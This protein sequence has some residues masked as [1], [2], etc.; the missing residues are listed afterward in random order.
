VTLTAAATETAFAL[1]LGPR[2]VATDSASDYP[3]EAVPLPDVAAFGSVDVEK[4]VGAGADLVIA[5]GNG[6]TPPDG[7]DRL[8]QLHVPVVVV[9]A[10]TIDAAYGDVALIGRAAGVADAGAALV[11]SMQ[12]QIEALTKAVSGEP[13]PKVFYEVDATNE[14]YGPA[15]ESFLTQML[16]LADADPVT[17]GSADSYQIPLER[18]VAANPDVIV[19]G[20][21]AYGVT[22]DVV[23]ARAGWRTIAAVINGDI[24][25][26]DDKLITRP[27]PRLAEGLRSL[28]LAIHPDA[29]L[30]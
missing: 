22:L 17:S 7:I 2:V 13:R 16:T 30:P 20:D 29:K 18:L 24:R 27:G 25:S 15:D 26:A 1:G 4:I 9:Y 23:K 11:A 14:I 6:D 3:P 19:L 8:R 10:R 21:A 12:G 5:G 28:I